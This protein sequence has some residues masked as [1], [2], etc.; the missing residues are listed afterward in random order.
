[1]L[2]SQIDRAVRLLRALLL[3]VLVA[4]ASSASAASSDPFVTIGTGSPD[5]VYYPIGRG[6]CRIV[7]RNREEHGL[8]CSVEA[9][10]G[11][12]Y[13]ARMLDDKQLEFA[14]LQGDVLYEARVGTGRWAEGPLDT[15]RSVMPLH[16]EIATLVVD[17][18]LGIKQLSDLVGKPVNG[19]HPGSGS[20][21]SYEAMV[22]AFDLGRESLGPPSELRSSALPDALCNGRIAAFFEVLGHPSGLVRTTRQQCGAQLLPLAEPVIERMVAERT[23]L[24]MLDIPGSHYGMVEDVPSFG[25]HAVLTTRADVADDVVYLLTSQLLANFDEVRSLHPTLPELDDGV[26]SAMAMG[27]PLHPGAER[28]YRELGLLP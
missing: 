1:M 20:R 2:S 6:L 18:Q 12:L 14:I 24:Q 21:S 16:P 19:G 10:A 17:G 13:N 28:A 15:L 9:T 26:L 8:R 3:V 7:N 4:M 25:S 11:S 27:A 22:A 23:Y 5:G